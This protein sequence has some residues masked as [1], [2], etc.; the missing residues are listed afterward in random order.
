[1][2]WL[3]L[4]LLLLFTSINVCSYKHKHYDRVA[5]REVDRFVTGS[6][7]TLCHNVTGYRAL[8][9]H[10]F[11]YCVKP[12]TQ[13]LHYR[14][15]NASYG[16][17]VNATYAVTQRQRQMLTIMDD[18]LS[19]Y[20]GS[21]REFDII[22][23]LIDS[24][25]VSGWISQLE[26]ME[27]SQLKVPIYNIVRREDSHPHNLMFLDTDYSSWMKENSSMVATLKSQRPYHEKIPKAAFR[28]LDCIYFCIEEKP[29]Y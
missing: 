8:I 17:L 18:V 22:I 23:N 21:R 13:L 20:K 4:S 11:D 14:I 10:F 15:V 12:E 7:I 27:C 19:S 9:Q 29:Y 3:V 25:F 6:N 1:M 5:K 2:V 28:G 26:R 16:F 24:P